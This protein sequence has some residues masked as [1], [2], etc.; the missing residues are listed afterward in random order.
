MQIKPVN[1]ELIWPIPYVQT[2]KIKVIK[3][4]MFIYGTYAFVIVP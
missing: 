2:L 4:K 1:H 3:I